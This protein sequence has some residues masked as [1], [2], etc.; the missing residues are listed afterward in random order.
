MSKKTPQQAIV[1]LL[2]AMLLIL[3][4]LVAAYVSLGRMLIPRVDDYRPQIERLLSAALN[5][6]VHIQALSGE[7]HYLDPRLEIDGFRIGN[8]TAGI[9]FNRLTVEL[10]SFQSLLERDLVVSDL[11]IDSLSLRLTQNPS[12]AWQID[13]MPVAETPPDL[14][15]LLTSLPYLE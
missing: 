14:S 9:T 13:G 6:P 1:N 11:F 4:V 8:D 15:I 5:V 12:G 2:E 7:W 10:N 3:L